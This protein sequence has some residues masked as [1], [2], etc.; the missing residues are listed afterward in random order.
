LYAAFAGFIAHVTYLKRDG[1]TRDFAGTGRFDARSGVAGE[2]AFVKR[3]EDAAAGLRI[4]VSPLETGSSSTS[5]LI[6]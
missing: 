1:V 2:D 3:S 5:S 4:I 6:R